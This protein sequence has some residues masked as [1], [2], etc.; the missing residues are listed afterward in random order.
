[1]HIPHPEFSCRNF[2]LIDLHIFLLF[3]NSMSVL[4]SHVVFPF[5]FFL[6]KSDGL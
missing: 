4:A 5:F 1:M 2:H 6:P 3:L